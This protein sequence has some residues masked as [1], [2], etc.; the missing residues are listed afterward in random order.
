[1]AK[2]GHRAGLSAGGH[3]AVQTPP[4]RLQGVGRRGCTTSVAEP[5]TMRTGRGADTMS[6]LLSDMDVTGESKIIWLED[7]GALEYVRQAVHGTPTARA[8]PLSTA[9]A[10]WWATQNSTQ[11]W[12]ET[13]RPACSTAGSSTSSPTTVIAPPTA[14]TERVHPVKPSTHRPWTSAGLGRRPIVRRGGR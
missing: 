2:M 8:N 9:W 1:M 10:A 5:R 6:S 13:R 3:Y 4:S 14:T 7:T 11:A 12:S